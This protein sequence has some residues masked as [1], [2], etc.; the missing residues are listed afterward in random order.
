MTG[1]DSDSGRSG[2]RA[3]GSTHAHAHTAKARHRA[4]TAAAS[5]V[6]QAGPACRRGSSP[7]VSCAVTQRAASGDCASSRQAVPVT[8]PSRCTP[9]PVV[10]VRHRGGLEREQVAAIPAPHWPC[11]RFQARTQAGRSILRAQAPQPRLR[12][13]EASRQDPAVTNRDGRAP[14]S[15]TRRPTATR[16]RRGSDGAPA[17][18]AQRGIAI[19]LACSTATWRP[20]A[21][22]V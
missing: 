6:S 19:R 16:Q 22:T 15:S 10:V 20:S 8:T 11:L 14:C 21:P 5:R 18:L 3:V 12:P 13:P 17:A 7:S 1:A 4:R 9:L 2:T